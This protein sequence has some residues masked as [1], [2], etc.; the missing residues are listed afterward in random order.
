VATFGS[1]DNR[2]SLAGDALQLHPLV[3]L[4][5]DGVFED[6]WFEQAIEKPW[7]VDQVVGNMVGA[8][9]AVAPAAADP[10][11]FAAPE[12][13]RRLSAPGETAWL[14]TTRP[15]YHSHFAVRPQALGARVVFAIYHPDTWHD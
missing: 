8:S 4:V 14:G 2:R 15:H 13:L 11:W 3:C 12:Y 7:V 5:T 1:A 9:S 10:S 6:A